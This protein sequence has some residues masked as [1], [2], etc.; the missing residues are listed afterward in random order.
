M[1]GARPQLAELRIADPRSRW[2]ALGFSIGDDSN[3]DVG[4]V[5]LRLGCD[6]HGIIGWTISRIDPGTSGI[7]GLPTEA[8]IADHPPR[9]PVEHPNGAIGID[10]VV[11]V[12]PDFDRTSLA[13][14]QAG[15]PLRRIT[16]T[17]GSR[18]GFRRLG[19]AILEL[20][21]T[22][23]GDGVTDGPARFWGLVVIVED[24]EALSDRLGELLGSIRP[25]VQP[26]RRIA[27]LR[28]EA[29]LSPNVAF[30]NPEP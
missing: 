6:G 24:M 20:V 29:G 26:G 11:I 3:L 13:L 2:E 27:T 1:S 4:G 25:A 22:R 16:E 23:G 18:Q 9:P 17:R 10:Q 7:D 21:E 28:E 12:T 8:A 19:S 30:M 14:D 15:I 5:R